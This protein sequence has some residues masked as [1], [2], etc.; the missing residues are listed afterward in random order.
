VLGGFAPGQLYPGGALTAA[1]GITLTDTGATISDT[2]ARTAIVSRTTSDTLTFSDSITK[3]NSFAR[4]ASDTGLTVT[5]LVSSSRNRAVTDAAATVSGD[6][7]RRDVARSVSDTACTVSDSIARSQ[8]FARTTSD[9]GATVT[10]AVAWR[11]TRALA[12]TGASI[13]GDTL[14]LFGR[15]FITD[16]AATVTDSIA[17][18][19]VFNR[20]PSDTAVALSDAVD[21]VGNAVRFITD[22][23]ANVTDAVGVVWP[24]TLT[25]TGATITDSLSPHRLRSLVDVAVTPSDIIRR[26]MQRQIVDTGATITELLIGNDL[27]A[28]RIQ[29]SGSAGSISGATYGATVSPGEFAPGDWTGYRS[30]VWYQWLAPYTGKFRFRVHPGPTGVPFTDPDP[31][32]AVYEY[33][34]GA[35]HPTLGKLVVW[36]DDASWYDSDYQDSVVNFRAEAGASYVIQ[37]GAEWTNPSFKQESAFE[38]TW[39]DIG[40]LAPEADDFPG[41]VLT[42]NIIVAGNPEFCTPEPND[43]WYW[44]RERADWF[45]SDMSW[46]QYGPSNR[47]MIYKFTPTEAGETVVS[48]FENGNP[49]SETGETIAYLF[50][51]DG[52]SDVADLDD[53]RIID[54]AWYIYGGGEVFTFT[55][56]AGRDYYL[57]VAS[58]DLYSSPEGRFRMKVRWPAAAGGTPPNDDLVDAE[59]LDDGLWH[60]GTTENATWE[61]IPSRGQNEE[62]ESNLLDNNPVETPE[63][64]T[65]WY[66]ASFFTESASFQFD[67]RNM[68][69]DVLIEYWEPTAYRI[70]ET[71][72]QLVDTACTITDG[73]TVDDRTSWEI[74]DTAVTFTEALALKVTRRL[75]DTGA[76]IT[77]VVQKGPADTG[78]ERMTDAIAKQVSRKMTDNAGSFSGPGV[79]SFMQNPRVARGRSVTDTGAT[80]SDSIA[81]IELTHFDLVDTGVAFSDTLTRPPIVYQRST[82]GVATTITDAL[83]RIPP[84]TVV[85]TGATISDMV[86]RTGLVRRLYDQGSLMTDSVSTNRPRVTDWGIDFMWDFI[87]KR[88]IL[89]RATTDTACTISD[90]IT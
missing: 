33:D 12:D 11:V 63:P 47:T 34:P 86:V 50:D 78:V 40:A 32:M 6:A 84:V 45:W 69:A 7:L 24:R 77:D 90:G 73:I 3:I 39:Q 20:A 49:G 27:Y 29:I 52:V 55:A 54:S 23:G 46:G 1:T 61:D 59:S 4:T 13:V 9:T 18:S 28:N 5:D 10:D 42:N 35:V 89:A 67:W 64:A 81:I 57:W 37:V 53:T 19:R 58:D 85:D 65:V 14:E 71:V 48:F 74:G 8:V 26:L 51:G 70:D 17:L 76:T 88:K 62:F 75:T 41:T 15:P 83:T 16:T 66:K 25:D 36:N 38:L 82:V 68:D 22:Q 79:S 56:V 44:I 2:V 30:T 60:P 80:I 31:W 72:R 21:L 87:N 43:P